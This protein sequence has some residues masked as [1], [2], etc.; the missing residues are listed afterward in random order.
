MTLAC[1]VA[2]VIIPDI[3]WWLCLNSILQ[4]DVPLDTS[5]T[6]IALVCMDHVLCSVSLHA[7]KC[8]AFACSVTVTPI[9]TQRLLVH[10][11]LS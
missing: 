10:R 3:K 11:R 5:F 7:K 6:V 8:L 2:P 1:H 4:I 9:L